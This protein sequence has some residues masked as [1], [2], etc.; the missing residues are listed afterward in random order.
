MNGIPSKESLRTQIAEIFRQI[1]VIDNQSGRKR[2]ALLGKNE[3]DTL[4]QQVVTCCREDT[5]VRLDYRDMLVMLDEARRGLCAI[6]DEQDR[7]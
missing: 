2:R 5:G 3:L 6:V 4:E 1:A 7:G